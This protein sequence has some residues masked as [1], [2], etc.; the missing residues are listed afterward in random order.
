MS[1]MQNFGAT[2]QTDAIRNNRGADR[3]DAWIWP[4]LERLQG[5]NK[6]I[7]AVQRESCT[8]SAASLVSRES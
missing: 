3:P 8:T 5:S 7:T 6:Q 2:K 1:K 4:F